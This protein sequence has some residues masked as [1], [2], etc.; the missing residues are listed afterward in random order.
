[1]SNLSKLLVIIQFFCLTYLVFFANI[2]SSGIFP[3]L[4]ILG[5]ILAIWSVFA[6]GIGRFN[7]QPEVKSQSKLVTKGPYKIIRNPMYTGLILFFGAGVLNVL[8]IID[9]SVFIILCIVLLSKI[10]LEEKYLAAKFGTSYDDYKKKSY[11][12]FPYIY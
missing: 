8:N 10:N 6:M 3:I 12:L 7:I 5:F 4:Q 2:A 9:L 1:M 11:R